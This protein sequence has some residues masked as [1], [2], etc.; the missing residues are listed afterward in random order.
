MLISR[1]S[2]EIITRVRWDS[3][4]SNLARH[5][6]KCDGQEAPKTQKIVEFA[7]GSTYS[8]GRMRFLL[9]KWVSVRRRPYVIIEDPELLEIFC[10]LYA[11]VEVPHPTTLSHDIR[12]IFKISREQLSLTLE[13]RDS[14]VMYSPLLTIPQKHDG[15]FHLCL[16]G[17]SSPNVISFL[18]VTA[19][20]V[21][22]SKLQRFILDF[23]K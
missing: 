22:E 6:R 16:D 7:H 23:I 12:E 15:K 18:G 13:V 5:V 9:A 20:R 3:L 8:K 11:K 21:V 19:Q 14:C 2:N 4:T 17:W 10:M 1:S